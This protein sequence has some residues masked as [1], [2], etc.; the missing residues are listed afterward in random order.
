MVRLKVS[1]DLPTFFFAF[2]LFNGYVKF[3]QVC[4]EVR[5]ATD[6]ELPSSYVEE[7]RYTLI[8]F[9]FLNRCLTNV[10]DFFASLVS[11][12]LFN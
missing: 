2:N 6:E 3:I 4:K 10:S 7:Y 9:L 11:V 12:V 8:T 5:P 1:G